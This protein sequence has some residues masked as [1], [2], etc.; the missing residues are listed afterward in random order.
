[1][2]KIHILEKKLNEI[3]FDSNNCAGT[4]TPYYEDE[5]GNVYEATWNYTYGFPFGYWPTDYYGNHMFCVGEPYTTHG[6]ACGQAAE[7]YVTYTL[8]EQI[9]DASYRL[10]DAFEEFEDNFKEYGYH[11][12]EDDDNFVSEDG[13]EEKDVYDFTEDIV[14]SLDVYVDVYDYVK[15]CIEEFLFNDTKFPDS[16]EIQNYLLENVGEEYDFTT[17]DGIERA[18]KDNDIDFYWFFEQGYGQGRVWPGEQMIGFYP[19]EQ[20]DP[21]SLRRI[22]YDLQD[23]SDLTV[24]ELLGYMMIF[25]DWGNNGEVT[26]CTVS[27]YI[28]GNYGPESYEDE[29]DDEPIQ[30]NNGQKTVFVPH[31]ANQDQK[32]EF[33]KDF[34]NTRDQAVYVPREKGAGSLAAYHAMRYPYGESKDRIGKIITEVINNMIKG[35]TT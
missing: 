32:R 27:D 35:E 19:S 26:A 8:E 4:D 18:L 15:H 2:K 24:G 9:G 17:K 12:N 21:E 7:R 30:Y 11:Y 22:L 23:N 29:D 3:R 31:L 20:P 33:F 25:E 34:R 16:Q 6:D 13:S 28:D 1:M 14:N 10:A 5:N